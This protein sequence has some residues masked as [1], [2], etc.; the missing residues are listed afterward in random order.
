MWLSFDSLHAISTACHLIEPDVIAIRLDE[1]YPILEDHWVVGGD[2]RPRASEFVAL[3]RWLASAP[4]MSRDWLLFQILSR[5]SREDGPRP[6]HR[7][8][9]RC[10][11]SV[12]IKGSIVL[13]LSFAT[14]MNADPLSFAFLRDFGRHQYSATMP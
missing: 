14:S 8:R 6:G 1:T 13:V 11:L 12:R 4:C 3:L 10:I 9:T 5:F 2:G 7:H